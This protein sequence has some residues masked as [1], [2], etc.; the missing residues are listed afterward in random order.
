MNDEMI[1]YKKKLKMN[2][3]DI[4]LNTLDQ[5]SSSTLGPVSASMA[6]HLWM[7]KLPRCRTRHRGLLSLSL[8]SMGRRV[9]Y[10]VKAGGVI[11]HIV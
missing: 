8:Q 10:Q 1:K 9:E 5:C 4:W 2:E 7:G 6:D 3:R 11:R